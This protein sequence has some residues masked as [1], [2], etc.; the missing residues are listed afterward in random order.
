MVE[1]N[2]LSKE[3][4][5]AKFEL[6]RKLN[7][8]LEELNAGPDC[9]AD[10]R[11]RIEQLI[12]DTKKEIQNDQ[13]TKDRIKK[14]KEENNKESNKEKDNYSQEFPRKGLNRKR[15]GFIT[16]E[17]GILGNKTKKPNQET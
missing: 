7:A 14:R 1:E 16:K 10:K 6:L 3:E 11:D 17:R 9:F 12:F 15:K 2:L 13:Q 5:S 4:V 8:E